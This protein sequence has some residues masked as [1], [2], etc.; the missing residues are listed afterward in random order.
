MTWALACL[1]GKGQTFARPFF[2]G[3]KWALFLT[4]T[5]IMKTMILPAT[6]LLGFFLCYNPIYAAT[7]LTGESVRVSTPIEGNVYAGAGQI[8]IDAAVNGDVNAGAGELW[9]MDTIRRDLVVGGGRIH[10]NGVIGEDLRCGGGSVS[11]RGAVLG[12]V[13]VGCG[14]L[15][16]GPDAVIHGDLV[17]GGGR[18]KVY[19]R[20]LGSLVMAGG[21]IEFNG[22][23]EKDTEIR[24]G[25]ATL[26]GVFR[27]PCK[28]AAE[29]L[30]L[31]PNAKFYQN[32]RYWQKNGEVDFAGSLQ[33]GARATFDESLQRDMGKPEGAW[34]IEA[35]S[36][37]FLYRL[38]V[39]ALMIALLVLLFDTFFKRS[40]QS[41][42][43]QWLGRFG[44]GVLYFIG[45]PVAMVLLFIT[46]IGIPFG[47]FA[48][49]LY[50]FTLVFAL[51]LTATVGTY[52]LEQ[53]RR[54]T[55]TKGQRILVGIALLLGLK[56]IFWIPVL[57][58]LAVGIAV[59][60]AFGSIIKS[61]SG[62]S[63]V[64]ETGI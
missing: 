33:E 10:I 44:I 36:W 23:A 42:P 47:L 28:F 35:F 26:N 9:V 43:A 45:L 32:V 20:I 5:V 46:V 61:L 37:F 16:I 52:A 11:L 7:I 55:W 27:G 31:G 6:L 2:D 12:D 54:L 14:E 13:V 1:Y 39:G 56:L 60:V 62:P 18:V 51:A 38:L 15:E 41:L 21:E 49:F 24:A 57:G 59:A 17:V 34:A 22:E 19:G 8:T 53:Y 48:F 40:G 29:T 50:I 63:A 30:R 64:A 25:D 4:N 3:E 58:F